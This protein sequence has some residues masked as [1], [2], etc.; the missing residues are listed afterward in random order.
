MNPS[1]INLLILGCNAKV[2]A[3]CQAKM[4]DDCIPKRDPTQPIDPTVGREHFWVDKSMD[5]K[6]KYCVA[7]RKRVHQVRGSDSGLKCI[8]CQAICHVQCK[9]KYLRLCAPCVVSRDTPDKVRPPHIPSGSERKI[10]FLQKS[11]NPFVHPSN[12]RF[13]VNFD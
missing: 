3:D 8:C 1:N 2:H 7:C 12:T 9:D 10:S 5:K 11:A 6:A 13:F 4:P